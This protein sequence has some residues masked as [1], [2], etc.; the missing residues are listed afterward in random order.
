[1][2]SRAAPAVEATPAAGGT[3]REAPFTPAVPFTAARGPRL[4]EA[5]FSERG[6]PPALAPLLGQAPGHSGTLHSYRI[7]QG[8]PL[9]AGSGAGC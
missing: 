5:C 9:G 6:A 7:S 1:M 3:G 4:G 2:R 8:V